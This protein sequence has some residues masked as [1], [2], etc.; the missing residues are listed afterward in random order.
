MV[1]NGSAQTRDLVVRCCAHLVEAHSSR[2]KSGWQNLFSV[3]TIAAG[4]PST[5]IGE[6]SFLTAQKVIEKRFKEDFPAFL[7]SFQEAL[8]CLQEFASST[9]KFHVFYAIFKLIEFFF[10]LAHTFENVE[11]SSLKWLKNWYFRKFSEKKIEFFSKKWLKIEHFRYVS[12]NS[13]K[14]DEAARRD[15]HLHKG[16]T[17]DQHV[18]L[19]GWFPIFFELSCIIN[20]CKLDVR[21]RSLTVMFEIMKHHGSDFRPEWWK[22]LLEIVFRIFDPSKMDDHRSDKREWM[23]TTCNHA[24]LSVVEV[25]TQFYT[26]LSVYA[27]PMIYRQ[28]GIFIRQQNEQ[29]ARCTISC[30]ESLISQNGERFTE[31]M[32]EQTIE[33]IRELFETTLPKSLLTWE[34]PN[35]N[36]IGSED[37]TN[38]SDTLSSEQIVFCVVQNELVEAVSRIVLGDHRES[39]RDLQID[40]LFTQ[41]SPQLLLSI[42]DALAES[43]TLAKQFNNNNG[44]RVLI[45]KARLLGSTKPNLINQETRSL[46]AM[47]AILFRLLYDLRAQSIS[48]KIAIRVLEVVSLALSGYGEAESDTRRTAYGPVICE[49]LRECIALPTNLIPVLGPEFPLKLCDLVETAEDQTMRKLLAE[50]FRRIINFQTKSPTTVQEALEESQ[51]SHI[52]E[53]FT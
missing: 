33:L 46:S 27:L 7:D 25:F 11:N 49:L 47:L 17:A 51:K 50:L 31:P 39:K 35:S 48:D 19:R 6:A 18:W 29:L 42:C 44:Q 41:M 16:L 1:R 36:G 12:E 22:D 38:G 45:W 28:F 9:K 30:L 43:H 53:N 26:Q 20:R 37:R 24:M 5:E 23:S 15:D 13:D 52:S 32:W 3:W 34:P 40:G 10:F 2:L 8:K 14:I 4:D 21:T